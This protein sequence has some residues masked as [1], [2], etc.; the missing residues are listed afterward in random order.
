[1]AIWAAL[2]GPRELLIVPKKETKTDISQRGT[3]G[4]RHEGVMERRCF[5][6]LMGYL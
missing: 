5:E 3:W 6:R 2:I 4:G 1:M